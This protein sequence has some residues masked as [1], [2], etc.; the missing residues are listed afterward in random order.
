MIISG[1]NVSNALANYMVTLLMSDGR[2]SMR[3]FIWPET[4]SVG[5]GVDTTGIGWD[6][7]VLKA[8][9]ESYNKTDEELK[10]ILQSNNMELEDLFL[11]LA[12]QCSGFIRCSIASINHYDCCMLV[13]TKEIKK[14]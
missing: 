3:H 7:N 1:Y 10:L 4:L 13:R 5:L 11:S 8:Q 12:V 14:C 2:T 6:E 9:L